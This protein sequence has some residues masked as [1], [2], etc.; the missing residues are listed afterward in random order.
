MKYGLVAIDDYKY[1]DIGQ[2]LDGDFCNLE[3]SC[4]YRGEAL[5]KSWI[6]A[7]IYDIFEL[8]M[9]GKSIGAEA[10][11]DLSGFI[12]AEYYWLTI[13]DIK[14]ALQRGCTGSY[15]EIYD[16]LDVPVI[17]GWIRSY[18][19]ERVQ[20]SE[21]RRRKQEAEDMKHENSVVMPQEIKD[22]F[23][24][25]ETKMNVQKAQKA[26]R[27]SHFKSVEQYCE[28]TGED[29][30]ETISKIDDEVENLWKHMGEELE[31]FGMT[32]EHLTKIETQKFL[33]QKS[34]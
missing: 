19:A 6:I 7:L 8:V 29:L 27:S 25:L 18:A 3:S 16:R 11:T 1:K 14:L 26:L 17:M 33:K 22:S 12:I 5:T 2:I 24:A 9:V 15:G 10:I 32:K 23:A 28:E 13:P 34:K 31:E 21:M 30:N 20:V 4:I